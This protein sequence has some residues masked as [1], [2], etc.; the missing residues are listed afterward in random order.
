[1]ELKETL[2]KLGLNEKESSV[3]LAALQLGP[4]TVY[5]IAQKAE[6]KRPGTYHV[7]NELVMKGI[8]SASKERHRTLYTPLSPKELFTAWK[9]RFEYFEASLPDLNALHNE[10]RSKPRIQ[11]FEGK[12]GILT[13]Y[14]KLMNEK[15]KSDDELIFY[16]AISAIEK[17]FPEQIENWKRVVRK[18]K[19]FKTRDLVEYTPEG[20]AYAERMKKQKKP[21][22]YHL[23]ILPQG[24]TFGFI[25]SAIFKDTLIILSLKGDIFATVIQSQDVADAYRT[26]F[27]C[28]WQS[29]T[30]IF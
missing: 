18:V 11:I 10:A 7:V 12:K 14:A 29:S 20:H 21:H 15:I 13:V 17:Y 6:L 4:A 24:M 25:D 16:G 5:D 1:M 3:Y 23:K 9:Q 28:A 2:Q 27:D 30:P 19:Q 26:L 8:M 22:G